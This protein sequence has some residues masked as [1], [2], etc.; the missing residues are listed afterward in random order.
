MARG[1]NKVILI[2]NAVEYANSQRK[3]SVARE[4]LLRAFDAISD[5]SQNSS[6]SKQDQQLIRA[7]IKD[8]L[9]AIAKKKVIQQPKERPNNATFLLLRNKLK[10]TN[11]GKTDPEAKKAPENKHCFLTNFRTPKYARSQNRAFN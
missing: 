4:A 11:D 9:K 6:Y 1:I 8:A 7:R 5:P 10:P 2:G 3:F